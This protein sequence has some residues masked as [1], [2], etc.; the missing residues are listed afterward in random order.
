MD[1]GTLWRALL[2]FGTIEKVG[3][4]EG[5]SVFQI[6]IGT[7]WD[8]ETLK[9]AVIARIQAYEPSTGRNVPRYGNL[10]SSCFEQRIIRII[11]EQ[12]GVTEYDVTPEKGLIEH[13][14]ADSLDTIELVMALEDEFGIEIPDEVA[15]SV[16][17]VADILHHPFWAKHG[18]K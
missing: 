6:D 7:S 14:Q 13:L 15:E 2:K 5:S 10:Y 4:S 18:V 1:D 9:D 12:L 16:V 11:A 3:D 17:T 8:H